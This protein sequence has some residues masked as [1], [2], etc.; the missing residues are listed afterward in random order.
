MSP[1]RAGVLPDRALRAAARDGWITGTTALEDAQFQPSSL[2]LRLGA[3]A[4]QLRGS[5]N[6]MAAIAAPTAIASVGAWMTVSTATMPSGPTI[7]TRR[8]LH[9]R[10][11]A[12]I[13]AKVVT[14]RPSAADRRPASLANTRTAGAKTSGASMSG[15]RS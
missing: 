10:R 15:A 14:A 2:D 12:L 5:R 13:S 1:A 7:R 6:P 8:P 4:Y 11:P 3:T 9:R